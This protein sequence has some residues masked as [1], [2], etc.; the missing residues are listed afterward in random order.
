[1]RLTIKKVESPSSALASPESWSSQRSRFKE[2][3]R[4]M[5][6][7]VQSRPPLMSDDDMTGARVFIF[8]RSMKKRLSVSRKWNMQKN[9][10][11]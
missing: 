8:A 3:G 11:H 10:G 5:A 9:E 4:E 6:A 7:Q 2:A 1:M